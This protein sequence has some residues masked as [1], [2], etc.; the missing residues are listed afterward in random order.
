M[1]LMKARTALGVLSSAI[2]C[3]ALV[4]PIGC[5]EDKGSLIPNN[6]PSV[7][8]TAFPPDSGTSNYNVEF[9][10]EGWDSDGE[11]DYYLYAIDP[12]DMYGIQ[13]SIWTRTDDHSGS[14]IFEAAD[15][16][17]LYPW[18]DPQIAKSWHVF[19]IKAVD[20]MGTMSEP[21]FLA[22]NAAT[23]APRTQITT[24]APE[25]A[26]QGYMGS[27]QDVG[28][29][30]T[31]RWE[32]EDMDGLLS[33]EPVAYLIKVTDVGG[34]SGWFRLADIVWRDTTAW[35]ERREGENKLE[36]TLDDNHNYA[37]SVRAVDEAGAAEPL[38]LLNG[39]MLWVGAR[40]SGSLPE[41]T[42]RSALLGER[43]WQGWTQDMETYEVPLGSRYE[44]GIEGN[45]NWYG[46]LV[47]GFSYAWDL[48]DV[49]S[50]ETDPEG[51]GAWTPWSEFR[52]VIIAEFD[53]VRDYFLNIRCK[54]DGGGMALATIRFHVV[55]LESPKS[56]CYIDD[57]RR[58]PKTGI[59]GE[60]LD[61]EVWQSM[62][63]G[64]NYDEDWEDVSWDEWDADNV[65]DMPTLKFLSH[66]RVVVWSLNDNRSTAVNQKSAWFVM[67]YTNTTNVL[68]VYQTGRT[69]SGER[70]KVWAFGRGLV[71]SSLLPE[72]GI[73]CSYP[74]IVDDDRSV[75]P[76]CGIRSGSFAM[77]AM[78]ITGEFEIS[79]KRSGGSRV[80][81]FEEIGD[82]PMHVYVDA[83]GPAIP[84]HLYTRPP[85]AELYPNLPPKLARHKAW[86]N[87]S[88]WNT[89]FEVLEYPE[90]DQEHQDIFYD[91][92]KEE[93]TGLIPL[94]RV[95]TMYSSSGA[96]NKYCG[97]RYVPPG[98]DD[99]GEIVYFFFP[100]FLF[101]D[102]HIRATAKVVLSDW[103]GLPDPDLAGS[104]ANAEPRR[105]GGMLN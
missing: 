36:L 15:Y 98:A 83:E 55:P 95:R 41:L 76:T 75:N 54:D 64:Y 23:I 14:F 79:D 24:P 97:F 103:F 21:E 3:L 60:P 28:L 17:T 65:E 87:R 7:R 26:I 1:C 99:P 67:N 9:C 20:D 93:M 56:L 42:L 101:N 11:I 70:G 49:E 12:P 80:S 61:D 5:D 90:P 38:L 51:E 35:I 48:E 57:W 84:E 27:S 19:V 105:G 4:S 10:W 102:N 73:F 34:E 62:L 91:P 50:N 89:Y 92:V 32:G 72:L 46:G 8:L 22:F 44:L 85:A 30:V 78:H 6:P 40:K 69:A 71:E 25:A 13:D 81:L 104:A 100:M 43:T 88:S 63:R 82:R 29:R 33:N 68:S 31:L 58:Y 2:V 39:N 66:F 96:D 37:I 74:Y 53:E 47:T 16:D 59:D 18:K 77:D 45:A 94:F 52:K 86:W